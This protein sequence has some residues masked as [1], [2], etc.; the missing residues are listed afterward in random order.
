MRIEITAQ[1]FISDHDGY[2]S[3][4]ECELS[5]RDIKHVIDLDKIES[6]QDK[7]DEYWIR[8]LPE[9]KINTSGS[10]FCSNSIQCTRSGLDI[11]DF[12]YK[13]TSIRKISL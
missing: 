3:D 2:C 9:P 13:N 4:N 7:N 12:T 8:F 10:Y 6:I 11:H 5:V 1:L